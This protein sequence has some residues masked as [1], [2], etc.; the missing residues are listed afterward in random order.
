MRGA[1]GLPLPDRR[2]GLSAHDFQQGA[3]AAQVILARAVNDGAAPTVPARW[4]L[5]LTNLL[6]GLPPEGPDALAAMRTRGHDLL[7]L[8]R[9]LDAAPERRR[10]PRPGP[11]PPAG[12]FPAQL[13]VTQVE[14]LVRD[15]YAAYARAILRL[16]K[17]DPL[18]R[19]PDARERGTL[20]H[21]V[22]ERFV[23]RTQ[24]G[25]PEDPAAIYRETCAQVLAETVPWPAARAMWAARLESLAAWFLAG[26]AE[27][28]RIAT[29]CRR[30]AGGLCAVEDLPAPFRLYARADRI[31]L[32]PEGAAIYDYKG[33]IAG[34][35]K[36]LDYAKQVPLEAAMLLRGA[37]EGVRADRIAVLQIL[38]LG[39]GGRTVDYDPA[40][41]PDTWDELRALI[42]AY[43]A[44]G[45]AFP[46]RARPDLC[47][48][49]GDYDHL[50]RRGEWFDGDAFA[51]E[52]LE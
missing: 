49:T 9:R 5:R 35:Q 11:V 30:E 39:G 31:D 32:G 20:S 16:R 21:A 33:S 41:V 46:P 1:I 23:E 36:T 4:L 52:Q 34:V 2:I 27:R 18:G 37:F 45:L 10:A 42:A 8:A 17:L 29:P 24:S 7:R 25:L 26:E 15:P 50:S 48:D 47:H 12:A 6:G 13:S 22:L 40:G 19:E 51:E 3:A 44:G 28:R 38:G 43:Q 14:T